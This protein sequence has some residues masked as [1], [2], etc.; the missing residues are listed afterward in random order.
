MSQTEQRLSD[1]LQAIAP[2]TQ[3]VGYHDVIRRAHRERRRRVLSAT[4]GSL[5]VAAVLVLVGIL[6]SSSTGHPDRLNVAPLA[7]PA[8]TGPTPDST[9][10]CLPE[11]PILSSTSVQ[12]GQSLTV[13]GPANE[14]GA[15]RA[16]TTYT[17]VL[18][19]VGRAA[20]AIL[21]VVN[22]HQDGSY[23]AS[24]TIPA[25]ASPGEAYIIVEPST[26]EMSCRDVRDQS[27]SCAGLMARITVLPATTHTSP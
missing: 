1:L 5:V 11:P 8:Q 21:G 25:D 26:T 2:D 4:G 17:I 13:V 15:A 22:G 27:A 3:G 14:C 10:G 23:T 6:V 7:T 18:G 9:V 16:G 20:P 12:A 24:V 19:Q